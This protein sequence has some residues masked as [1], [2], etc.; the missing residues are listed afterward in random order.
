MRRIG[1]TPAE[2]GPTGYGNCPDVLE[3]GEGSFSAVS[4][5]PAAGQA[6]GR[7]V[8]PPGASTGSRRMQG[9][10]EDDERIFQIVC[11]Q[12]QRIL[13]LI[14]IAAVGVTV[15]FLTL[16]CS[17]TVA[18]MRDLPAWRRYLPLALF[19]ISNGASALRAF[20]IPQTANAIAFP[21]TLAAIVLS[22]HEIRTRRG[23]NRAGLPAG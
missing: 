19:L 5:V 20:D 2:R 15:F 9:V 7:A 13:M 23:R 17:L 1:S 4:K 6:P 3:L 16:W 14:A 21:L 22:L 18:R 10:A 8:Q 11:R 12:R